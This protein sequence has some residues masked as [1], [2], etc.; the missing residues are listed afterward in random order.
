MDFIDLAKARYSVRKYADTPVEDE[1]IARI[2]EAARVAPTGKNNQPQRVYVLKSE[3]ALAKANE[4]T[5]CIFGAPLAFLICYDQTEC[6]VNPLEEGV[7]VGEVDATI[8]A[9]HMMLEAAD[10]GLGTCMVGYFAPS[11]AHDAFGLPDTVRPVMFLP[12]G[13]PAAD[14]E[15]AA[16]HGAFRPDGD[17]VFEL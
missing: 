4:L 11:K 7:D 13:Y 17:W 3:D 1:K 5:P 8:V 9:T 16:R 12:C 10:L 2:L 6:W 14:S 15:P